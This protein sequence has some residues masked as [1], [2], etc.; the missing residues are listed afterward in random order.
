MAAI[1]PRDDEPPDLYP[2]GEELARFLEIGRRMSRRLGSDADDFCGEL[3]ELLCRHHD[4]IEGVPPERRPRYV[5]TIA[6][7]LRKDF[8]AKAAKRNKQHAEA[9]E[10]V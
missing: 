10:G 2:D 9:P 5:A 6:R 3:G 4:K 7:N 1:P 8:Y